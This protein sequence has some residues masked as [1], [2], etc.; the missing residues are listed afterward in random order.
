M[1]T[2]TYTLIDS[3]T[4]GSSASSVTF[5]SIPAGGDL[6]VVADFNTTTS[7][8]DVFLKF[9][10]SSSGYNYVSM[11]GDGSATQSYSFSNLSNF[12]FT[13]SNTTSGAK[14]SFIVNLLDYSATNKH[15][16][17]LARWNDPNAEAGA[18]AIR[19]ASNAAINRL[20]VTT[21]S[22]FAA[23]STFFLYNIAKA[24]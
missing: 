4:L 11:E 22:S 16:S 2:P 7:N 14:S 15:K 12:S 23:G 5:S 20:D 10:N 18:Y 3:V 8:G 24:L 21:N 13:Y 1:P 17:M 19:W 6:V 9:N